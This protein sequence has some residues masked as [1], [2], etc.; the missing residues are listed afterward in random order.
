M[1]EETLVLGWDV[2]CMKPLRNYRLLCD[3]CAV[4]T[5]RGFIIARGCDLAELVA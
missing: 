4:S 1:V 5:A 2:G 3:R